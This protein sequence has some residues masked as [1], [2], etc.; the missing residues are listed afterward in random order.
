MPDLEDT[1]VILRNYGTNEF[2]NK[3]VER[4]LEMKSQK[5]LTKVETWMS[6][7]LVL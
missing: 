4:D 5:S 1:N 2:E 3:S 6:K 7:N